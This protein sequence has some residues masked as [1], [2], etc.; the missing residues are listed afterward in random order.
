MRS[1]SDQEFLE[2]EAL[3]RQRLAQLAEHAPTA[4]WMPDEVPV[5][6]IKRHRS[7]RRQLGAIA[8]ATALLGAGGFTTYSFL[9][10]G[11]DGGAATPEEAVTTF[12]SGI[13]HSDV[14]GMIDV[15]M[16]EEAGVLRDAVDSAT[17]DANRLGLLG[18]DFDATGV[19]GVDTSVKDLKLETNYLE[20]GLATVT[21][22]SGTFNM[23]FDP[24][25]F[26]FGSKVRALLD[27]GQ[28]AN[29]RSTSLG[30]TNPPALLVTV[31]RHGRWYVSLEYTIAEYIRRSA[32]WE[33]PAPVTRSPIGFDS[34]EAATNAFYD[35]L[36]ALDLRGALELAAPGE[37]AI[38]WLAQSWIA[39]A[40]AAIAR[41]R[42][43]GW[44]VAVSGLTYETIGSG[45]HRTLNPIT[46]KVQ[47]T[48]PAGFNKASG[49]YADPSLPTVVMT[50][51]GSGFA[52][53]PPGVQV[54]ATSAGISFTAFTAGFPQ[55]GKNYNFTSTNPDGTITPLVFV[56]DTT[57]GPQPFTIERADGCTTYRG[58]GVKNAFELAGSPSMKPVDGGFQL[59]GQGAVGAI[60]IL[61]LSGGGAELPAVSV[62]ESGG[63]WYVSPLGTVLASV[64]TSL[65]DAASGSSLF[66]TPLAPFFYGGLSR[67]SLALMT[68][69]QPVESFA[70][71]CL[72][73]LTV[74]NGVVTGVVA[75]PPPQAVRACSTITSSSS[76][77]GAVA[78][79]SPAVQA[80]TATTLSLAQA[81]LATTP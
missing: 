57:G 22:T 29:S 20:G 79:P 4:V 8:A 25:A 64:T 35:R 38:P 26:P 3:L 55:Q 69:G 63:K 73:A 81:P 45:S 48:V 39:D 31:Q 67:G 5:V 77:G 27:G 62:V 11:D 54:P 44:T 78:P 9:A 47:G 30:A 41:G 42:A 18:N 80:T 59:C 66:D 2:T 28:Q 61:L 49:G 32:G 60:S 46:F 19:K 1:L 16:P 58:E 6:A 23:S 36:A 37:D 76:S 33:M 34:P 43:N 56:P 52:L 53:V 50:P 17:S 70:P 74:A 75:D 51:D 65:H 40:E 68:T 12:V 15:T 72:T 13:E 7:N 21:A 10:A 14:L 24:Q 71:A